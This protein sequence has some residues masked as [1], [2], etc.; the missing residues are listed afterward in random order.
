[1]ILIGKNKKDKIE[2]EGKVLKM[3]I[4]LSLFQLEVSNKAD[5]KKRFFGLE[6]FIKSRWKSSLFEEKVIVKYYHYKYNL[7]L[8][9]NCTEIKSYFSSMMHLDDEYDVTPRSKNG[10]DIASFSLMFKDTNPVFVIL[11]SGLEYESKNMK[12]QK[13]R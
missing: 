7:E 6:H 9:L 4:L 10:N 8:P 3:K 12:R 11:T 2:F 1:M 13:Q 5:W